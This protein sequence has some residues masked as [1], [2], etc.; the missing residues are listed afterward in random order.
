MIAMPIQ[1]DAQN[2]LYKIQFICVEIHNTKSSNSIE[3]EP[4]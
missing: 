1:I 4:S 3:S 2:K